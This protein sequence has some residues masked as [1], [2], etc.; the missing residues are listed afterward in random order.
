MPSEPL[1]YLA[2]N[3]AN[4]DSR[5]PIHAQNYGIEGLLEDPSALSQVVAFDRSRL[6]DL[7]GL[8]VVHLQCHIGTDT[9][10]LHRLGGHVTG[11]DLSKVLRDRLG[12][13]PTSLPSRPPPAPSR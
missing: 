1:D 11:V 8:D 5:A 4:W 13:E 10:S 3:R 2:V 9:L 12:D 7:T 6:G